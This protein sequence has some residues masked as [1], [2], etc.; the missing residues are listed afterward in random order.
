VKTAEQNAVS[1]ANNQ[2]SE[3]PFFS[4]EAAG[5]FFGESKG[6]QTS[7]FK[8]SSHY[9]INGN[10]V[11]Q[12]KL[13]IGRPDDK[14]EQEAD[15]MAD[16][17]VQRLAT[18]DVQTKRE[19]TIQA[20]P[21]ATHITPL[22]QTKCAT[23]EQEDKLQKKE[24]E[25]LVQ[26]SPLELQRKPIFESNAEP[27]DDENNIQRKCVEC[28]KEEQL[29]KKSDSPDLPTA[30]SNIESS[31]NSSKG[32]GSP[33]PAAT[34]EQM[35]SSFGTDFSNV[36]IHNDSS[37]VQMNKDL[38][39]QAFTHGIDIYFNSGKYDANTNP[40]K[41]LLAH[42]LTHVVQQNHIMPINEIQKMG[43][44]AKIP[45]DVP[46]EIARSS[47]PA[48][49]E[50]TILFGN[51]V[52]TLTS[53][54]MMIID[55][56]ASNWNASGKTDEI[57]IDG[58]ASK[59]GSEE[60]NWRLS[61]SRALAVANELMTPSDG[62]EGVPSGFIQVFAQGETDEFG[63][64]AE[65]R[66]AKIGIQFTITTPAKKKKITKQ[67]RN[68]EMKYDTSFGPSSSNCSFYNSASAKHWLTWTYRHNAS[69]ACENTP[70]N[71][72]NNCVRKCLQVKG[73]SFLSSLRGGG[74][75]GTCIDPIGLLDPLCP[76][77]FCDS[78]YQQHVDCYKECCC[79]DSFINEPTFYTM[80][81]APFPCFFVGGTIDWFNE[82]E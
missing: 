81:E 79:N 82:C 21:L 51:R 49:G 46:C 17:V 30:S 36:R 5:S 18:P 31:L 62:S 75:I 61:C 65:N 68:C 44:P 47:E 39:A 58:Y 76:E 15:A 71:P 19:T 10:G 41:H 34:E 37:S 2:K 23:C 78:I 53:D 80:C 16:K 28:E 77:P 3:Q 43:D 45:S 48:S 69:C 4:K 52:A 29:Q 64:I 13:T 50:E 25:D 1:V 55:D 8:P 26:E 11:I 70:D 72:K 67:R 54:Q 7:F 42:E 59:P 66:R 20:K 24:E 33:I 32:N 27:P 9:N 38:H 22:L 12:P 6:G 74:V 73:A 63:P 14:Y 60:L 35:E 57:R 40:G 56:L